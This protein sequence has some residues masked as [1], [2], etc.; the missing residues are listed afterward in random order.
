MLSCEQYQC[1]LFNLLINNPADSFLSYANPENL[2]KYFLNLF[3]DSQDLRELF[4][5]V[6]RKSVESFEI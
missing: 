4:L 1:N 3:L 6:A 2:L 5:L